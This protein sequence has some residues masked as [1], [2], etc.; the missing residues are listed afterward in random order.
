MSPRPGGGEFVEAIH[1]HEAGSERVRLDSG[2]ARLP[3]LP[4]LLHAR[5]RHDVTYPDDVREVG[6]GSSRCDHPD[7]H[8]QFGRPTIP[9]PARFPERRRCRDGTC[10]PPRCVRSRSRARAG[11]S[12]VL[13]G[14][15]LA[16][17]DLVP[18]T[19]SRGVRAHLLVGVHRRR[20]PPRA[21][22]KFLAFGIHEIA[23]RRKARTASTK[24]VGDMFIQLMQVG[25]NPSA[26]TTDRVLDGPTDQAWIDPWMRHLSPLGVDY[27]DRSTV[28]AI[29]VADGQISGVQIEDAEGP[30]S[31]SPATTTSVRCRSS[32]W[33]RC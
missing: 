6:R 14:A 2:G 28:T 33:C 11:R 9:F 20:D 4:G 24:T 18:R 3:V 17:A 26:S 32:G 10:R 31:S 19:T 22:Q 7:R 15:D 25:A 5:D 16:V 8:L 1:A 29:H 13:R 30:V 12:G 27:H 21:Y 23:R